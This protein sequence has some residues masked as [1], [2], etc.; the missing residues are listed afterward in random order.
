MARRRIAIFG[1]EKLALDVTEYLDTADNDIIVV[2]QSEAN[3]E[4]ARKR[5]FDTAQVD[6]SRDADLKGA[7]IGRDIDTVFCLLPSDAENVFLVISARALDPKVRI[8]SIADS[9]GSIPKFLAAGADKVVDPYEISGRKIWRLFKR[10]II[11]EVMETTLFGEPDLHVAQVR[12]AAG[13]FLDGRYVEGLSLR[14]HYDL[15]LLGM[16]DRDISD[17]FIFRT[18]GY[19]HKLDAGDIL[20]VIGPRGAIEGLKRDLGESPGGS[21]A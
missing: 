17:Q 10:P 18:R 2:D 21:S 19:N 5:G 9:P 8:I 15:V 16:V 12:I 13:S 4:L 6:Y 1:Y 20:V 7:G 11:A 3:L 14:D